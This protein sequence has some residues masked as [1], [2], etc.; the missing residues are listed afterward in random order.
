MDQTFL[1]VCGVQ[2]QRLWTLAAASG[3]LNKKPF[4]LVLSF[5]REKKVQASFLNKAILQEV[6]VGLLEQAESSA[7]GFV[8][9]P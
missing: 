2:R 5:A 6:P 1:K 3:I 8:I 9:N 4:S 7:Y